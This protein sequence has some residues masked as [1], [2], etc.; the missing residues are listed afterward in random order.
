MPRLSSSLKD[1]LGVELYVDMGY[2]YAYDIDYQP[3]N[4]GVFVKKVSN[5]PNVVNICFKDKCYEEA[6]K[7]DEETELAVCPYDSC[8]SIRDPVVC[9][10]PKN[11]KG[12]ESF[13]DLCNWDYP[14]S[15]C[16]KR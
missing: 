14:S 6:N 11:T 16:S 12:C 2:F 3:E 13:L 15:V 10:N 8:E 7:V 5:N 9:Q 1:D 4:I